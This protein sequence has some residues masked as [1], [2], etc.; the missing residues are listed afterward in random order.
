MILDDPTIFTR[1]VLAEICRVGKETFRMSE[2]E[3]ILSIEAGKLNLGN[4]KDLLPNNK[5]VHRALVANN[6]DNLLYLE[7]KDR[8][9]E[10][11]RD[12]VQRNPF[13]IEWVLDQTEDLCLLAVQGNPDAII[14]IRHPS[15]KVMV[16]AVKKDPKVLRLINKQTFN[17]CWEA[18]KEDKFSCNRV[19]NYVRRFKHLYA[20]L[21]RANRETGKTFRELTEYLCVGEH[22]GREGLKRRELFERRLG[23]K[24][25]WLHESG[26][27]IYLNVPD[28]EAFVRLHYK[29]LAIGQI[30][31][32]EADPLT[33]EGMQKILKIYENE[34]SN[35]VAGP[36]DSLADLTEGMSKPEIRAAEASLLSL[37]PEMEKIVPQLKTVMVQLREAI[38]ELFEPKAPPTT[39][40]AAAVVSG[41]GVDATHIWP[42]KGQKR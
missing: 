5:E 21:K 42:I 23:M 20:I 36:I 34:V 6:P 30:V 32:Q 28:L 12:C 18:Y 41:L 15:E 38:K 14:K 39:G 2:E 27:R 11:C 8:T 17:V 16:E 40:A 13:T 37:L 35:R 26:G 33:Q 4:F 25:S 22:N 31:T 9:P 10:V 29:F 7:P 24:L 3:T 1:E 19:L